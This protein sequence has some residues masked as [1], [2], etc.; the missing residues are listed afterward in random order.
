MLYRVLTNWKMVWS[1][2]HETLIL[3]NVFS[4]MVPDAHNVF[5]TYRS[6]Q[7]SVD[8]T[9]VDTMQSTYTLTISIEMCWLNTVECAKILFHGF[10]LESLFP[11][12]LE[13]ITS[14]LGTH[15]GFDE[16]PATDVIKFCRFLFTVWWTKHQKYNSIPWNVDGR[17]DGRERER[18]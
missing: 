14:F 10:F 3:T 9:N 2:K 6:R 18:D 8:I 1:L 5:C 13:W 15:L 12:C 7:L 4:S 16:A 11:L 17:T